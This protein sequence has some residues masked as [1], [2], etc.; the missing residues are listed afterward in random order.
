M[1]A[2]QALAGASEQRWRQWVWRRRSKPLTSTSGVS[3]PRLPCQR[4]IGY[5]LSGSVTS[6]KQA[7]GRSR[8][9]QHRAAERKR[10]ACRPA[11]AGANPSTSSPD[12]SHSQ[13]NTLSEERRELSAFSPSSDFPLFHPISPVRNP[14]SLSFLPLSC[15]TPSRLRRANAR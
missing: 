15:G 13:L 10:A 3:A 11:Q 1:A 4:A 5:I 8:H 2:G 12:Q 7:K 6:T 14:Q 9:S